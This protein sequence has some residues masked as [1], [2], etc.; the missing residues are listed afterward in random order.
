MLL[1]SGVPST[2]A[3]FNAFQK[4]ARQREVNALTKAAINLIQLVSDWTMLVMKLSK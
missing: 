1:L 3:I 4:V 2:G